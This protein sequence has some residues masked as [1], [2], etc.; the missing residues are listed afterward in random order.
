MAGLT[1]KIEPG[2]DLDATE[3]QANF[4]DLATM[5]NDTKAW[6]VERGSVDT[7]HLSGTWREVGAETDVIS[8]GTGLTSWTKVVPSGTVNWTATSGQ[9]VLAIAEVMVEEVGSPAASAECRVQ[10]YVD[11]S[12]VASTIRNFTLQADEKR[13]IQIAHLFQA[14]ASTHTIELYVQEVAGS[15][16]FSAAQII[17]TRVHR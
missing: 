16:D 10:I 8:V 2:N 4:D 7:R 12:G 11:S 17:V 14:G 9:A 15:V 3:V 13:A 6:M 1:N 5:A